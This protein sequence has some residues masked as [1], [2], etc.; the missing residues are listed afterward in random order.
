[1][2]KYCPAC[3]K[4]QPEEPAATCPECGEPLPYASGYDEATE[5]PLA[6]LPLRTAIE[7]W[8]STR[9]RRV[10]HLRRGKSFFPIIGAVIWLAVILVITAGAL[11]DGKPK[12]GPYV[13][14]GVMTIFWI[15]GF[16]LLYVGVRGR[17]LRTTVLLEPDR[18][19]IERN[20]FGWKSADQTPLAGTTPAD[21]VVA[22]EESY[23][24]VFAVR[25]SGAERKIQFG[26]ALD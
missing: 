1:M 23:K 10:F 13:V 11:G 17:F 15:V 22:Y 12:D 5:E 26:A 24:P 4:P 21:L 19:A 16:V 9:E 14:A 3:L 2:T 20:L 7:V 25:V 8:Q 6:P 18:L